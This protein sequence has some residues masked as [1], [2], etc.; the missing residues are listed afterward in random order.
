MKSNPVPLLS[1]RQWWRR[2]L[3]LVWLTCLQVRIFHHEPY[4][5]FVQQGSAVIVRPMLGKPVILTHCYVR[6]LSEGIQTALQNS[7]TLPRR[8]AENWNVYFKK[9]LSTA[10]PVLSGALRFTSVCLRALF[11]SYTQMV[12]YV[13]SCVVVTDLQRTSL[14]HK[15]CLS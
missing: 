7:Q 3:S 2:V 4:W 14:S 13:G 8:R 12:N 10:S 5:E 15:V 6:G 11:K 1:C 9:I